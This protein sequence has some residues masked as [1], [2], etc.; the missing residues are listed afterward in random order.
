MKV[1]M[2]MVRKLAEQL[3]E[4]EIAQL[5][6]HYYQEDEL[7]YIFNKMKE[8]ID[9]RNNGIPRD[10]K[11]V[12]SKKEPKTPKRKSVNTSIFNEMGLV[13]ASE[14]QR[15]KAQKEQDNLNM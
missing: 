12:P 3:K 4:D 2:Q 10:A 14:L 13:T 6:V 9:N 1:T 15:K 7:E 5:D 8:I 11:Y